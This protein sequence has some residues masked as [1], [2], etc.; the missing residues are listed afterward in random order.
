MRLTKTFIPLLGFLLFFAGCRED[1]PTY[2][3]FCDQ[4][5]AVHTTGAPKCLHYAVL[6]TRDKALL[7]KCFGIVDDPECDYRLELTRYHVSDCNNPVVKS[8]GSDFDGY[9]R[10]EIKKGFACYYKVQSDFKSDE[11]AALERVLVRFKKEMILS[12]TNL[13]IIL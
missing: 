9:I 1:F 5:T 3:T 4:S 7:E 2:S 13:G 8:V 11:E 12:K 6:N 10:I